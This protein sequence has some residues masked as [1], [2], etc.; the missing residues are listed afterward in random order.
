MATGKIPLENEFIWIGVETGTSL[1]N[2]TRPG[3]YRVWGTYEDAHST[4]NIYG[5]L[6]V[7]G[8]Q[9]NNAWVQIYLGATGGHVWYRG[10]T[11]SQ[12]YEWQ[13][14][15]MT[16]N[17]PLLSM[18]S[19]DG[20]SFNKNLLLLAP[21]NPNANQ[22]KRAFFYIASGDTSTFSNMP[23]VMA[24]K[25]TNTGFIGVREVYYRSSIHIGVK[26]TEFYPDAG[27]EYYNFYN[28]GTWSGW[29]TTPK[30]KGISW[31]TSLSANLA[32]DAH[33]GTI[34]VNHSTRIQ[35][36]FPSTG[37]NVTIMSSSGI[38]DISSTG[39]SVTF[40]FN[41]SSGSDFTITRSGYNITIKSATERSMSIIS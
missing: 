25:L 20:S 38:F 17:A 9:S 2:V 11:N 22:H 32:N 23:S 31:G 36:W 33:Q 19:A 6:I 21:N 1:N 15:E 7:V 5:S 3:V 14:L 8:N 12:W 28:N 35:V 24:G 10:Y 39:N 13:K 4:G 16:E 27:T 41:G 34:I 29:R 40:G 30:Q 26:I 18:Q 37:I